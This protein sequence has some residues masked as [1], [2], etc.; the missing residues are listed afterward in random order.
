[1]VHFEKSSKKNLGKFYRKFGLNY[2]PLIASVCQ[3]EL[4]NVGLKY[5]LN[6]YRTKRHEIKEHLKLKLKER[7]EKDYSINL[8]EIFFHK[9]TFPEEINNLNLLRVLNQIY[10]EKAMYE[11]QSSIT[12]YQ[13]NYLV[14]AIRNEA[15]LAVGEANLVAN[16]TIIKTSQI[17]LDFKL[18]QT[19]ASELNKNLRALDFYSGNPKESIKQIVSFCFLNSMINN[20]KFIFH[21][22][23]K[24]TDMYLLQRSISK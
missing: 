16:N 7:L 15:E 22:A 19:H 20:Q 4:M 12:T 11:K 13:T 1:M 18:E 24:S 14:R 9:L 21:A 10:N 8:F 3:S 17:E 5:S 23:D 2:R 6:E